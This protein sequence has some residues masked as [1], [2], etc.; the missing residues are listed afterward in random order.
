MKLVSSSLTL[1][2]DVDDPPIPDKNL[3]FRVQHSSGP[4]VNVARNPWSALNVL[5]CQSRSRDSDIA[6]ERAVRFQQGHFIT[7]KKLLHRSDGQAQAADRHR[8]D[9]HC[10]LGL[11]A[12]SSSR[13]SGRLEIHRS[14]SSAT[15]SI[16]IAKCC[17]RSVIVVD[18]NRSGLY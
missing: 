1:E 17:S 3:R 2:R 11:L 5:L 14:G 12:I 13:I 10:I 15:L 4:G 7:L 6:N 16:T 18:S 8:A 9:H